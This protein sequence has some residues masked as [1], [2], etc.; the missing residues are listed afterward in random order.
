MSAEDIAARYRQ[1]VEVERGWRDM[2]SVL[3]PATGLPPAR[4]AHPRPHVILCWLALL[5]I[6]AAESTAGQTWPAMRRELQRIAIG[7][8][9][10]PTGTFRQRTASPRR[11]ATCSQP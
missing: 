7:T 11:P 5:L 10:G 4:R 1:L 6:R 9:T 2:K 8:F 3:D